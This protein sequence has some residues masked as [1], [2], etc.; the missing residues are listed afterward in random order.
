M[1]TTRSDYFEF[2]EERKKIK[3]SVLPTDDDFSSA[4]DNIIK[5]NEEYAEFLEK[6]YSWIYPQ[7]QK[8]D[9]LEKIIQNLDNKGNQVYNFQDLV[10]IDV[11]KQHIK[12]WHLV[13]RNFDTLFKQFKIKNSATKV[14]WKWWMGVIFW[15]AK[16]SIIKK[17]NDEF[18]CGEVLSYYKEFK[19]KWT[20]WLFAKSGNRKS[21]ISWTDCETV[22]SIFGYCGIPLRIALNKNKAKI[23]IKK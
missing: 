13:F 1:I 16:Y 10:S 11:E 20:N 21:K 14:K 5:I 22:N 15:I 4:M 2:L 19:A 23:I 6:K 3:N 12:I 18:D 9:E 8:I 7:I 17:K